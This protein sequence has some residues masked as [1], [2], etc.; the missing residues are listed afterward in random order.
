MQ[1]LGVTTASLVV[2]NP[3]LENLLF[4]QFHNKFLES[5]D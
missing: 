1:L 5:F 3:Y 2:I 4:P